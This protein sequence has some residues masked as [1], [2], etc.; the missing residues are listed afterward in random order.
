MAINRVGLVLSGLALWG[1][2]PGGGAQPPGTPAPKADGAPAPSIEWHHN[3]DDAMAL[4]AREGKPLIAYFT[5]D[6]CIWCKKLE[7]DTFADPQVIARSRDLVWVEINRDHVAPE[8]IGPF[9]V[10]AFPSLIFL[11]DK[12]E[13]IYRFSSYMLPDA[14]LARLDEGFARHALYRAGEEWDTPTPRAEAICEALELGS[15]PAPSEGI[16]NGLAWLDGHLWL[17]QNAEQ[18]EGVRLFRIDEAGRIEREHAF[19]DPIADLA[20]DGHSLYA[21]PYGW[22]IGQPIV[23]VDPAT[24]GVTRRIV[25]EA[26]KQNTGWD[27]R[28]VEW[29]DG[30]L[31][32]LKGS[33][34]VLYQVE[35][36]GGAIV[37][38]VKV[39]ASWLTGLGRDGARFVIGGKERLIWFE[40]DEAGGGRIV[41]SVPMNY[42]LRSVEWHAGSAYLMEQPVFDFDK[43]NQRIRLWPRETVVHVVKLAPEAGVVGR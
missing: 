35:P 18:G 17:A 16:P 43:S 6:A 8:V 22:T 25:T 38:E 34:G 23:V 40:P 36:A 42:P 14:F 2:P 37:R 9:N 7:Q 3:L 29:V 11:G 1:A 24:G 28:G 27:C 26:N 15:I 19:E 12:K 20:T 31:W 10:S 13:K 32:L 5:F 21:A 33:S 39:G 4:A 30:S 41:R